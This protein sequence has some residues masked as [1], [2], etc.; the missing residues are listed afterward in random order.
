VR[1][2]SSPS[3]NDPSTLIATVAHGSATPWNADEI[4]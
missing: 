4:P 2:T 3:R 1:T